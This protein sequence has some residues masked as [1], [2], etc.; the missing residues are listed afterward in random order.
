MYIALAFVNGGGLALRWFRDEIAGLRDD[1]H[2]YS[3]LD[4]E[5][6]RVEPG[7]GSLLWFPHIQGCVLPPQPHVRGA[8][9]G[10]TSGHRRAHLFRAILEG[11][12]FEYAL[13][14]ERAPGTLSEA[15]VLGGGASSGLWNAI[16]ADVLGIEWVP[17]MRQEC[18][19]LGDALVAA[20]ATGH[21]RDLAAT[22][23]AWQQTQEPV[24]PEPERH[25]RYRRLLDAYRELRQLGPVFER[26]SEAK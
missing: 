5:A 24:R 25:T 8:F 17:T 12:A 16:K 7:A 3:T 1:P 15:R 20:V 18:G 19:V 22:A 4:A 6:A 26:L 2:A 23:K 13:W 9:V 14:A 21:V 11:I 10:L